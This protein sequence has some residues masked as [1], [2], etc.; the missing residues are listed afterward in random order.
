MIIEFEPNIV[1]ASCPPKWT[2]YYK[3][4]EEQYFNKIFLTYKQLKLFLETYG[5]QTD[6]IFELKKFG[7]DTKNMKQNTNF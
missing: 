1:L 4:D 6:N 7:I 2:L 3:T 5:Y